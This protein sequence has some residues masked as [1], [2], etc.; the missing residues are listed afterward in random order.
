MRILIIGGTGLISTGI[1]RALHARGDDVTLFN[2]GR[3]DLYPMPAGVRVLQGDRTDHA[4]FEARMAELGRW[5]C[6]IDMVGYRPEDGESA[7]RAFRGRTDQFLFCSTVDVYRKP[8][9]R[10]PYVEDE[11]YGGLNDYSR[12]KVTIERALRAAHERGDLPLTIIRPA[13]TYGE[14]R[15]PI[16]SFGGG[17]AYVD[18]I[19]K[20]K[21]IIVHG[22]GSSLWVACHRDDVAAAFAAAAGNPATLGR[23]YHATGEEWLTWND[24][25]R[26]AARALGAPEPELV[27][28]PTDLLV[29][30]A[31]KARICAENFQFNNIFDNTAAQRDLGFRYAV[32]W[33][34]GVRRMARWLDAHGKVEDSDL[35][36]TEDR[37]IAA[38]QQLGDAMAREL[39]PA[40]D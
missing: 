19:R 3:L 11:P 7:V 17:T 15:G 28:I 6:V 26:A 27:H 13:Y 18:R 23:W 9:T 34:E 35:D 10:Y 1:T 29:R 33:E 8:A 16:H 36:P 40:E 32:P 24:Y 30:V 25:H 5:D 31:P 12:N 39:A 38:W 4:A 14:G 20:G 21:P 37:L 2:R 22:D